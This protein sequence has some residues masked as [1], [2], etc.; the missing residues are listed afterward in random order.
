M[1]EVN[2]L[3]ARAALA[4][5]ATIGTAHAEGYLAQRPADLPPLRIGVGADGYGIEPK[6]IRL[7]TGKAYTLPIESTGLVE[8]A[9]VAPELFDYIWIRKLEVAG[10]EIKANRIHEIEME[11]EGEVELVF[12][13]IRP[14]TY[15]FACRGRE[16]Q[17]LVGTFVVR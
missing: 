5:V 6:E 15:P 2:H 10:V 8:C 1:A 3:L 7:E 4:L 17:G 11:K 13:P 12:V 16:R 9:W 14:G